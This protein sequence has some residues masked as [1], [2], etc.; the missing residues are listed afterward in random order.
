MIIVVIIIAFT[1]YFYSANQKQRKGTK[2]IERTVSPKAS[3]CNEG[4]FSDLAVRKGFGTHT[5]SM[6]EKAWSTSLWSRRDVGWVRALGENLAWQG[7]DNCV[8]FRIVRMQSPRS[9]MIDT[10]DPSS[11]SILISTVSLS[12]LISS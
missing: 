7:P 5:N 2:I 11:K 6:M 12:V 10:V 9:V 3:L 8:R 4:R 1:V